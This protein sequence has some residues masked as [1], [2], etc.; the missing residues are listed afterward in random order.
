M[1]LF[2]WHSESKICVCLSKRGC[3]SAFTLWMLNVLEVNVLYLIYR[4]A[5][6]TAN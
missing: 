2:A 6:T 3:V 4:M 1:E 5:A